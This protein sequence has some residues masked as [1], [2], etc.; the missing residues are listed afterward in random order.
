MNTLSFTGLVGGGAVIA[1][2]WRHIMTFG[3]YLFGLVIGESVIKH[4]AGEAV[5]SYTMHNSVKSPLGVKLFS[6]IETY[7][8]P[9]RRHE[10]VAYECLSS[11]PRIVKYKNSYALVC[12]LNNQNGGT[13]MNLGDLNINTTIKIKYI[14]GTFDIEN[15]ILD[16]I[17]F[18]NSKIKSNNVQSE[19]YK[20][21]TRFRIIR[22]G[23]RSIESGPKDW[24]APE[25]TSPGQSYPPEQDSNRICKGLTSGMYRLL[26]WDPDDLR[27]KPEDGKSPFSGYPFPQSVVE[28]I[29]ELN[30]WLKNE[31]WFREKSIPW[32]RGW[33]LHGTPGSG[34]STLTR[35]IGMTFDLP[36]YTYD[37]AGMNNTELSESWDRMLSNTPCIALIE[38]IDSVFK[39]RE[40]IGSKNGLGAHLTFDCLLN[41]INGVKSSDGIF[42]IIT[43]NHVD[44]LDPAL[45]V[46][47]SE[48][49]STRP[50]RID[51]VIKLGYMERSE[52]EVLA[53]YILS[54]FPDL[55]D[56]TVVSGE[57]ETAAQ[58]QN[59]CAQIA[60]AKFWDLHKYSN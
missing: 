41:C 19:S 43:T 16:S 25:P 12:L 28:S 42:L 13:G 23:G 46:P 32:R 48:G 47:N 21:L 36:I 9:K 40:Y 45:G 6:G 17:D 51:R 8:H 44:N 53:K 26:K 56:E 10:T 33:L 27:L 24:N 11:D 38:D 52:R 30:C 18:H 50:G 58:F 54:D 22:E 14:R 34:K 5:M 59:R 29:Q 1:A 55:I 7:L 3:R 49:K 15:F 60:L 57:G 39:G 35:A 31:K 20:K 37:L 2:S 4:S